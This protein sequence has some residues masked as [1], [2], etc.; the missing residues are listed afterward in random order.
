MKNIAECTKQNGYFIGTAYDGKLVFNEL[1]KTAPGDSVKIIEDGKKIWEITRGYGSDT[2]D[3]NSSSI[4]YRIDVY[5]ESINQTVSEYLVNFDYLNRVMS[6]YGFELVSREEAK[7]MGLPD[8]SGLFSELF[9]YMMDEIAKNKFKA[10]DYEK[11]S[12]MSGYEKKI[13]FLNRYFVY[14]KIRT[15]NVD[16]VELEVGEYADTE[17]SRSAVET[18]HAQNV[19]VEEVAAIKPKVRK[20]SKKLLLVA[21]TDAI[22][23][24]P[25]PTKT[26]KKR[27]PA[28]AKTKATSVKTTKKALIIESDDEDDNEDD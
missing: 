11:A 7:D 27:A 26:A 28:K 8:G 25:V 22:D 12:S 18:K 20:L 13:S 3:D 5:Q 4:G 14:K 24:A 16:D 6:A 23:D 10:K 2:F 1:R 15:V 17:I 9:L 19:A 21:A